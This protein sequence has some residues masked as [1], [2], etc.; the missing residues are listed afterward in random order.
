[1]LNVIEYWMPP[2]KATLLHK[3]YYCRYIFRN[4]R[5]VQRYLCRYMGH[6]TVKYF[7]LWLDNDS[8]NEQWTFFAMLMWCDND[9]NRDVNIDCEIGT[10]CI[11]CTCQN[12]QSYFIQTY[13]EVIFADRE[14]T[15]TM[16]RMHPAAWPWRT[17]AQRW[18]YFFVLKYLLGTE[19]YLYAFPKAID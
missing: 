2:L 14:G 5:Y 9:M 12:V 15:V 3:C 1:M 18:G 16:I 4:I 6:G 19:K 8:D 17:S 10:C 11:L 7:L 13:D